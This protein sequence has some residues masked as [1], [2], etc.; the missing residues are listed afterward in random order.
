M[1]ISVVHPITGK[2]LTYLQ[3]NSDPQFK[4][5]W[6]TSGANEL[7]RLT[8][9]VGDRIKGTDTIIFIEHAQVPKHNT[10]TYGRFVCDVRPQKSEPEQT[11]F[12]VGGNLINY[13]GDVSTQTVDLTTSKILWNSVISTLHAEYM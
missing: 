6:N 5:I 2:A 7:G 13:D 9:G 10:V 3:L 11:R 4:P 12:T 1:A 8:Q